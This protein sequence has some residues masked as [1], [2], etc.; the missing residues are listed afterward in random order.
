[1]DENEDDPEFDSLRSQP[2]RSYNDIVSEVL[3]QFMGLEGKDDTD[4]ISFAPS[5]IR[6]TRPVEADSV[7]HNTQKVDEERPTKVQVADD[8]T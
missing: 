1:M 8:M 7:K 4:G 3:D 2:P 6:H 5:W